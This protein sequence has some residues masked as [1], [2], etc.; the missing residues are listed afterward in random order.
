MKTLD[1]L[2]GAVAHWLADY[3]ADESSASTQRKPRV[4]LR[5]DGKSL[6]RRDESRKPL[7]VLA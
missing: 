6:P 3:G 2:H 7:S 5:T 1:G 4:V